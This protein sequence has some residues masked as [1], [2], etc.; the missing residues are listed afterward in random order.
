MWIIGGHAGVVVGLDVPEGLFRPKPFCDSVAG[1]GTASAQLEHP[2]SS[3]LVPAESTAAQPMEPP[4]LWSKG[5]QM[6]KSPSLKKSCE[7]V[8]DAVGI[9]SSWPG[10]GVIVAELLE[11]MCS[12][13]TNSSQSGSIICFSL[14]P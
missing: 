2:R 14:L 12:P 1:S 13:V 7:N 6:R 9:L 4:G 8:S 11:I 5:K 3:G 10:E